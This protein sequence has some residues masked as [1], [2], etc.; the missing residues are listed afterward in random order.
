MEVGRITSGCCCGRCL[1]RPS[2]GGRIR[3]DCLECLT[4]RP[5]HARLCS[6][7]ALHVAMK[8][9]R[10]PMEVGVSDDSAGESKVPSRRIGN[11]WGTRPN[12]KLHE[13][14]ASPK[15]KPHFPQAF[16]ERNP[17]IQGRLQHPMNMGITRLEVHSVSMLSYNKQRL[18]LQ[19]VRR[20][21]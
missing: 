7:Q 6:N 5:S 16:V 11:A 4:E 19:P 18:V 14:I 13:A 3:R 21:A 20:S 1:A 2:S 8:N 12:V 17:A 9:V 10:S 15:A